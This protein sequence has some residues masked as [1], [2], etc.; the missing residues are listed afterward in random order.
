MYYFPSA[1]ESSICA[2]IIIVIII[3]ILEDR[4]GLFMQV[5]FLFCGISVEKCS[6][7]SSSSR[8]L[9]ITAC[10]PRAKEQVQIAH[11]PGPLVSVC[12]C[13]VCMLLVTTVFLG[14][15]NHQPVPLV[16][17]FLW[18]ARL[19]RHG[20]HLVPFKLPIHRAHFVEGPFFWGFVCVPL[21][22]LIQGELLNAFL[23]KF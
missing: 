14:C 9:G 23:L 2:K 6:S 15:Q 17:V 16:C 1:M 20:A 10:E 11:V 8:A 22:Q 21:C 4:M 12:S 18:C 13:A 7:S 5:Y 3:I 19:G